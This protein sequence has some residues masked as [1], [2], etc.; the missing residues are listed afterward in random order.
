LA[1]DDFDLVFF[2][3]SVACTAKAQVKSSRDKRVDKMR[4]P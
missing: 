4:M 1:L 2:G 3:V